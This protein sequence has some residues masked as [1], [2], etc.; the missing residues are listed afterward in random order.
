MGAG[1]EETNERTELDGLLATE[2]DP[3][4]Q[5]AAYRAFRRARKDD[6]LSLKLPTPSRHGDVVRLARMAYRME[7]AKEPP[8]PSSVRT[9]LHHKN[10]WVRR[11]ALECVA[12][13]TDKAYLEDLK[14]S[15]IFYHEKRYREALDQTYVAIKKG[16]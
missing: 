10:P 8:T 13:S 15:S 1:I 9:A 4:V 14:R 11:L 3:F 2:S 5:V 12:T 6:L 16:R 7:V